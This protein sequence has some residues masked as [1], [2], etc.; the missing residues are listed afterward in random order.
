MGHVLG[1]LGRDLYQTVGEPRDVVVVA[2]RDVFRPQH[3]PGAGE[4]R[5]QLGGLAFLDR[6]QDVQVRERGTERRVRLV[7]VFGVGG[8]DSGDHVAG[9]VE[10]GRPGSGGLRAG[11]HVPGVGAPGF[12]GVEVEPGHDVPAVALGGGGLGV[13]VPA[14]AD[15]VELAGHEQVQSGEPEVFAAPVAD[16]ERRRRERPQFGILGLAHLLAGVGVD[17]GDVEATPRDG[18]GNGVGD[19]AA[20]AGDVVGPPGVGLPLHGGDEFRSGVGEAG[21]GGDDPS[22]RQTRSVRRHHVP[23]VTLWL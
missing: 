14:L 2:E 11:D 3:D 20:L 12:L 21:G 15:Q 18:V 17:L 4:A 23:P 7:G 8:P 22:P 6:L 13:G 16:T 1:D 5:V 9:D 10:C 19:I